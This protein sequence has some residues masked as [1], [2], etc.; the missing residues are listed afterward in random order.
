MKTPAQAV[1]QVAENLEFPLIFGDAEENAV[2]LFTGKEDGGC[3]VGS[4]KA[5]NVHVVCSF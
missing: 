5:S 3:D 1:L 2:D 4:Y